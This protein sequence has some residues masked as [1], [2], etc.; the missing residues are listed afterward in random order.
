MVKLGDLAKVI[1]SEIES[2][3]TGPVTENVG[4]VAQVGDSVAR[5]RGLDRAVYGELVE[6][7]GGSTGIVMNLE[8]DGVGCVLLSGESL[9]RDGDGPGVPAASWRCPSGLP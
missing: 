1:R 6:F 2:W 8:E 7:S 3:E 5:V 9:V 4:V